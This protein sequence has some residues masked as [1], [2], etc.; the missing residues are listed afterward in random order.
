MSLLRKL[1]EKGQK[2][3]AYTTRLRT[4]R[5]CRLA[6]CSSSSFL[7]TCRALI[8]SEASHIP[9]HARDLKFRVSGEELVD[10]IEWA[11]SSESSCA[12][13]KPPPFLW[14]MACVSAPEQHAPWRFPMGL[15]LILTRFLTGVGPSIL[16]C[17]PRGFNASA[18]SNA[19]KNCTQ[20]RGK[21]RSRGGGS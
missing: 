12:G 6:V 20:L 11:S 16:P 14:T 18:A 2:Y 8:C 13:V 7:L 1:S 15:T 9:N 5:A 3:N 21:A 19:A 17:L 4:Y 10:D